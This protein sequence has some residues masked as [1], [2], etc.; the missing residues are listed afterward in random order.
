MQCS[1]KEDKEGD[2]GEGAKQ[3]ARSMGGRRQSRQ[4]SR[5]ESETDGAGEKRRL[6]SDRESK[7]QEP[8]G[9]KEPCGGK[10]RLH[11]VEARL[12]AIYPEGA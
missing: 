12:A 10:Q 5:E 7:V 8:N 2:K 4:R 3:E 6:K 11:P 9:E 1:G